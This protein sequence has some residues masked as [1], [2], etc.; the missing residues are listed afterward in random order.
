MVLQNRFELLYVHMEE[1]ETP[2]DSR[3]KPYQVR[4]TALASLSM[5]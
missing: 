4:N 1:L 2:T 3:A 5:G